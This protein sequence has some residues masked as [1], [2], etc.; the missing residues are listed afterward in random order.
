MKQAGD[1]FNNASRMLDNVTDAG[2]NVVTTI[3][4]GRALGGLGKAVGGLFKGGEKVAQAAE[5]AEKTSAK[6][7]PTGPTSSAS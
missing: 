2:A 3:E 4:G 5:S 7:K 6:T 1:M